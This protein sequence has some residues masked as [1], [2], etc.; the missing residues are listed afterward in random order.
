MEVREIGDGKYEVFMDDPI[1]PMNCLSDIS[2]IILP[3]AMERPMLDESQCS[4]SHECGQPS[5]EAHQT[6]CQRRELTFDNQWRGP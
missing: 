5:N 6:I 2:H 4:I 1:E 3:T